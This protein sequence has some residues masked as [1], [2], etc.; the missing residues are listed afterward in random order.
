MGGV[1]DTGKGIEIM[2]GILAEGGHWRVRG[3]TKMASAE[4][5]ARACYLLNMNV[6]CNLNYACEVGPILCHKMSKT[7]RLSHLNSK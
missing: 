3:W 6:S 4:R 1:G 5:G 2:N 7:S